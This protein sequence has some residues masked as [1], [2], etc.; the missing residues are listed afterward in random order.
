MLDRDALKRY[1]D[2]VVEPLINDA[3][4]LAGKTLKYLHTDSWEVEPLNWTP[5]LRGKFLN[6][7]GYDP[8][9]WMPVLAG[10]I[11]N[12]REESNRFLNDFRKTLGDLAV[13]EHFQ[14][15]L[16]RAHKRGLQI[17]P[18][19]GGPHAVPIDAQRCLGQNDMPM[20]E[21]WAW[22]WRHRVGDQNRF[23]VKQPAS[24]AHTYGHRLVAA[25]GFTT[26]GPHWQ[27]T[28]WD[29]LKPAFDKALCEGLNLLFWHAFVCS[30]EE[31]GMPGQQYFAGTHFNPNT[32]WWSKSAPFM[33]YINRCQ[34]MLQRGLFVADACYYYGD[35]VP[36]F[37]QLKSSDPARLLPGYDYDVVT[38]E[39]LLTRMSVRDGR[40]VLPDGMSYRVLVLP[41]RTMISPPVLIRLTEL[42]KAGATVV[43][44]KP[45]F[46]S[47]LKNYPK[48]DA[49]VVKLGERIWGDCNGTT[50]KEHAFGKGRVVWGRSAREVLL[51]EGVKPDFEFTGGQSGAMTDYIHRQDHAAEVYFLANRSNRIERL[52]CTFRV[53]GKSPE[54][55]NAVTGE[56][57]LATAYVEKEGRTTVPLE[58]APCGSWFVVFRESSKKHP[59]TTTSNGGTFS[60]L[61][62]LE[63]S[64]TVKF[65]P[66]WGGPA[67]AQ[68]DQLGSWSERA[69][70]GV[71]YY[72]GTATY[73]KSFDLPARQAKPSERLW[74][75]LGS[76][77]ELASVHV[78]GRDLG[79]VWTPPFRVDIT[80]VV[81]PSGNVLEADVVNFW[82]NRVIGDTTLPPD[83][84]LTKTNIRKLTAETPLMASGLLGPVRLL[85]SK[86]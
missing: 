83:R 77:R 15:F 11:I 25:E 28:I 33:S 72:S 36:N 26:I 13:D 2:A 9:P 46:A 39:T 63:G 55:W 84:R 67:R 37:A 44:P 76:L 31:M 18:E 82:P 54:L 38:E 53:S 12:S 1:W 45:T 27:E 22:S 85:V 3:G 56:R 34:F 47:S 49:D 73:T 8:L 68:F 65:D 58:F 43:G 19:S 60:T 21:F 7:R 74:L 52:D 80:D 50:V 35:H 17:H 59:A 79:I 70:P 61:T 81:K 66:K 48:C 20:S 30:P 40:I 41:D 10:R 24:A 57:R 42:V 78:N 6:Y 75:D 32:T 16:R 51:M 14:P 29:N 62:E 86:P 71:K 23:F 4:P 69:E 64:W 5:K